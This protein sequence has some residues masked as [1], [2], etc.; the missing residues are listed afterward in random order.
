MS[1][2]H[3]CLD[4]AEWMLDSLSPDAHHVRRMIKLRVYVITN[5]FVFPAC[6]ATL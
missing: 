4:R 3:P 1:G 2:T 5:S 6:H